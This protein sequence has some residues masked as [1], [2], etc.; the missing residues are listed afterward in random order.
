MARNKR[1]NGGKKGSRRPGRAMPKA[2]NVWYRGG[3]QF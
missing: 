2:K 1:R 3:T